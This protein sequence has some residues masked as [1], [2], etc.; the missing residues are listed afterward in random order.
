MLVWG[1][2]TPCLRSLTTHTF[3]GA[4]ELGIVHISIIRGAQEPR[5][6]Q[7]HRGV[8]SSH[9]MSADVQMSSPSTLK[10]ARTM[11]AAGYVYI[12]IYVFVHVYVYI[13]IYIY[14]LGFRGY[15]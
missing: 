9:L 2:V 7:N 14:G 1:M 3:G 6:L 8:K 5:N 11:E 13:Y 10:H 4:K 12:H 15:P